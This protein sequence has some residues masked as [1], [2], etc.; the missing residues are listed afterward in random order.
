MHE[1]LSLFRRKGSVTGLS[2]TTKN[3]LKNEIFN[4]KRI[5]KILYFK[6]KSCNRVCLAKITTFTQIF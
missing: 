2:P 6:R 4:M 5:L 3:K 1:F